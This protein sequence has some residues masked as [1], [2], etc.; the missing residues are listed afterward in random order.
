[1]ILIVADTGPVNYLVQIGCIEV[2]AQLA[3][4]TVLP[5][6][7]QAELV[8]RGAPDV[9]RAWA[10]A[11]PEWV[12]VRQATQFVEAKDLSPADREAIA[13]A[14]EM[15]AAVLLMDDRHAWLCAAALGVVTMGTLGLLEVA[16]AR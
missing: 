7:V 13:L 9:V 6:S 5:A 3:E 16:A 4:K 2:L 12:E 1:V 8:H 14:R 15:D 11:L 10:S